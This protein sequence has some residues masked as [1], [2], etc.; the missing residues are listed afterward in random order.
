MPA[1]LSA[2][3]EDQIVSTTRAFKAQLE[4]GKFTGNAKTC[5]LMP[6]T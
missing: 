6:L 2:L 3:E 5:S 1:G 4:R